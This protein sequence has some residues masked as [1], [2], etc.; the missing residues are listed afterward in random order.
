[1]DALSGAANPGR[2]SK[3]SRTP[4]AGLACHRASP[5][6]VTEPF[7]T[8][9]GFTPLTPGD[10]QNAGWVSLYSDPYARLATLL[11]VLRPEDVSQL[12]LLADERAEVRLAGFLAGDWTGRAKPHRGRR[13]VHRASKT[14]YESLRI[15]EA[16]DAP[17]IENSQVSASF[18]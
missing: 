7:S 17:I 10:L 12:V 1:M 13:V 14:S 5:R 6:P 9:S 4:D 3:R 11:W 2:H 8:G 16:I 15:G 18:L